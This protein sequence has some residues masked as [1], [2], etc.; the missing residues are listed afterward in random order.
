MLSC[1]PAT[2]GGAL[3]EQYLANQLR[4]FGVAPAVNGTYFQR[5]PIDIVGLR[6]ESLRA[7]ASGEATATL[8]YPDDV[9]M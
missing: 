1:G 2:R 3:T 7:N 9:V 8:R 6:R 5:V 4:S